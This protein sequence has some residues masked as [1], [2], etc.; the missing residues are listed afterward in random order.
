MG[1]F[2]LREEVKAA[3]VMVVCFDLDSEHDKCLGQFD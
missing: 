2:T 1:H 3:H